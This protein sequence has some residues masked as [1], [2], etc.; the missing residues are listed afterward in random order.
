MMTWY[1]NG[2]GSGGWVAMALMTVLW[3][4]LIVVAAW[5]AVRLLRR[6]A[7]STPTTPTTPTP[8]AILDERLARGEID[9]EQYA[10]M[11]RLIEGQSAVTPPTDARARP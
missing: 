6:D 10:Q 9:A 1:D 8:R 4:G 11:R 3:I 5:A 7:P 2:W